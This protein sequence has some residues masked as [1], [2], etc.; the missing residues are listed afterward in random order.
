MA[1]APVRRTRKGFST[2][3]T[4]DAIIAFD[5]VILDCEKFMA[6]QALLGEPTLLIELMIACYQGIRADLVGQLRDIG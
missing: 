1:A 3:V 6:G 5:M 2:E 4:R